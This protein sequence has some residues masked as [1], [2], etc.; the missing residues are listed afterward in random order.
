M[1]EKN[2][3]VKTPAEVAAEEVFGVKAESYDKWEENQEAFPALAEG[4][5]TVK[6]VQSE[7]VLDYAFNAKE[8]SW[9][10]KLRFGVEIPEGENVK[11]TEG[12]EYE[13]W[14]GLLFQDLNTEYMDFSKKDGS[15]HKTRAY[16][17]ALL[18]LDL[19]GA[20]ELKD[21]NVLMDK[22]CKVFVEVYEHQ[23]TGELKNRIS[24]CIK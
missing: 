11:D 24:K 16:L 20:I 15:P 14:K 18:D 10:I 19:K 3:G 13:E 22:T 7:A 4:I 9:I 17:C 8:K 6:V 2:N 1:E 5:Y 12:K 21:P 23:K